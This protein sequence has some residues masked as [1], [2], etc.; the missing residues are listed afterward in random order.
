MWYVV[1]VLFH[2]MAAVSVFVAHESS[3]LPCSIPGRVA[4]AGP[5]LLRNQITVEFNKGCSSVS[6]E[7]P[8]SYL[9]VWRPVRSKGSTLCLGL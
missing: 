2:T 8:S 7:S 1:C 6:E 5:R 3:Q 4:A 9:L